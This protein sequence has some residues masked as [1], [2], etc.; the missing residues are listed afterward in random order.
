MK[1]QRQ[2]GVGSGSEKQCQYITTKVL[3]L[4]N[5]ELLH[6]GESGPGNLSRKMIKEEKPN[7][8]YRTIHQQ[9]SVGH[10]VTLSVQLTQQNACF[11]SALPGP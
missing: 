9:S 8:K 5:S 10:Q 1:W 11:H 6:S 2:L 7:G 3:I 4:Q